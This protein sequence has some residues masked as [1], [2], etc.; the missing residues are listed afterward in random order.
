[1]KESEDLDTKVDWDIS[2]NY[3]EP[4]RIIQNKNLE[5]VKQLLNKYLIILDKYNQKCYIMFAHFFAN[6]N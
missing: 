2:V 1:M 4:L 5:R 3:Y 6:N